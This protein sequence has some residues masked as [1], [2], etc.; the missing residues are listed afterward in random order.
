MPFN[1]SPEEAEGYTTSIAQ[2]SP[3]LD[4]TVAEQ[5]G[6]AFLLENIPIA[7]ADDM[8]QPTQ[9]PN[10]DF[11]PRDYLRDGEE[12]YASR[13]ARAGSLEDMQE[14]RDEVERERELRF[15]LANGPLGEFLAT[16]IAVAADPTTYI[17]LG[18]AAVRGGRM[19]A[20][21]TAAGFSAAAENAVAEAVLH[22]TQ[23][24]RTIEES[25][26]AV[27][28]GGAIGM[29]LPVAS[30]AF[31]SGSEVFST[32][33]A[34][35]RDY[36]ELMRSQFPEETAGAAG[37]RPSP[38]D[39]QVADDFGATRLGRMLR[40]IGMASPSIELAASRNA[41]SR[42]TLLQLVDTGLIHQ[43]QVRGFAV[44]AQPVELRVRSYDRLVAGTSQLMR[45]NWTEYR[46]RTS[47][48]DR[49]FTS[50]TQFAEAVGQAMR[51]ND[52]SEFPEV[53]ATAQRL[54][55]EV[56]DP[57]LKEAQ[58]RGLIPDDIDVRTAPSYFT[59]VYDTAKIRARMPEFRARVEQYL[60]RTVPV[61]EVADDI[62]YRNMA[63]DIINK[64]LGS[65]AD[66][67]PFIRFSPK[68]RGPAKERTFNIRDEE[69]E[70]FL[71]SDALSVTN[72]YV[73]TLAP[74]IEMTR[75]FGR[76]DPG[77]EIGKK[78]M[79]DAMVRADNATTE[80]ERSSILK[81][82]EREVEVLQAM[83]DQI[84]GVRNRPTAQASFRGLRSLG[85]AFRTLQFTR[86][87]GSVLLSSIV[88]M[89]RIVQE[90]GL[91][92]TMG[93]VLRNFG[94]GFRGIR[95]GIKQAR[96]A[97]TALDIELA[98]T[99][100]NILD[101]GDRYATNSRFE[102]MTDAAGQFFSQMTLLNH[103]NTAMKGMTS[104]LVSTRI[105]R[106]VETLAQGGTL[107]K[108]DLRKLA[109]SG[110]DP[111]MAERIAQQRGHWQ[112]VDDLVF[113][114]VEEWD[115][116][117][118]AAA[119]RDA[120]LRDVDN[121]IIT[122]GVGDAPL[123]TTTEWGKTIFQFKRFAMASTN[124]LLIS[125]LQ[126]RDMQALNGMMVMIGLGALG[127]AMRDFTSGHPERI[128]ERTARQW[129]TNAID[130]SGILS[131]YMEFDQLLSKTTGGL[132]P[133]SLIG[134]EAPSRFAARNMAG[135]A[136]GPSFGGAQDLLTAT[137]SLF[138]GDVT[139]SDVHKWRR[140]VPGQNLFYTG[141]LFDQLERGIG[142]TFG[143]PE[144]GND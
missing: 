31:R 85:K 13:F 103:W 65:P 70:D 106:T 81:D 98:S 27:M 35:T 72:R 42:D 54:R 58:A 44:N 76:P 17:P 101:L 96:E 90:E 73:R 141:I 6:A 93:G 45:E 95:M 108:R 9:S 86:L 118:A 75:A 136:L 69:I 43:G 64:I 52:V 36:T 112:E 133:M 99:A 77:D 80:A 10:E 114:N 24:T 18:G 12:L 135:Q 107:S 56:Y 116:A 62:E 61:D 29:A 74:D 92:R 111:A 34:A 113:A 23:E 68:T 8:S 138:E 89:G 109:Q 37:A 14:I 48:G 53:A 129:V 128:Q 19:G 124:R 49:A 15:T 87:L 28:L 79:D 78:V 41:A 105:L 126:A 59:R 55:R 11:D 4:I 143:L 1:V 123:W 60:R 120:V 16:T 137:R 91:Y 63:E 94:T 38:I 131:L 132:S 88:D 40:R 130:R 57:L 67:V 140:L 32:H 33:R 97:G 125:G 66:R 71:V 127:T 51:R 82:A 50:E 5:L 134:G 122:P 30:T 144:T 22:G 117:A 115:D 100:R 104:S 3:G 46:K 110:I 84:R 119:M 139:Q 7:I 102:R 39:T 25:M 2:A 20:R 121:T 47:P 21:L 26:A 142:E 83:V